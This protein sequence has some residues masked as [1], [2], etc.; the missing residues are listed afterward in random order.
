MVISR[1]TRNSTGEGLFLD[2]HRLFR[3]I[4][5]QNRFI[6][7][8]PRSDLGLFETHV[9]CET[10]CQPGLTVGTLQALLQCDQGRLSHTLAALAGRRLLRLQSAKDDKRKRTVWVTGQGRRSLRTI[11]SFANPQIESSLQRLTEQQREHIAELYA[12]ISRS[13]GA[14]VSP[15]SRH[16]HHLRPLQRSAT[17]AFGLLGDSCFGSGMNSTSYQVLALLADLGG[18]VT[19][20][21]VA[22]VLNIRKNNL[23]SIL[24][25]FERAG[26]LKKIIDPDDK[27]HALL[28]LSEQGRSTFRRHERA[29]VAFLQ[30]ALDTT[31]HTT[32]SKYRAALRAYVEAGAERHPALGIRLQR[33]EGE[34]AAARTFL[35]RNMVRSGTEQHAPAVLCGAGSVTYAAMREDQLL[36]AIHF[37]PHAAH[38]QL[39]CIAWA[40]ELDRSAILHAIVDSAVRQ[41]LLSDPVTDVS[42]RQTFV[43]GTRTPA[44]QPEAISVLIPIDR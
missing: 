13:G 21:A 24:G 8:A 34:A 18:P 16:E 39:D 22:E 44:N 4:P 25:S 20:G 26:L 10:D 41:M 36:A 27:R 42:S 29:A 23:S 3:I 38:P 11:D 19:P 35:I 30:K 15:R 31:S 37:A 32:L 17:R 5:R 1:T 9:L 28:T 43:S 14:T 6:A 12:L 2:L 33:I 7:S 40:P